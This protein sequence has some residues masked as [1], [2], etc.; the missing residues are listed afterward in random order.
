[1]TSTKWIVA[2]IAYMTF[3]FFFPI[4]VSADS[5]TLATW[6]VRILSDSSRTD[7]ELG[8]IAQIMSRYDFIAVQEIRDTHVMDRL[9]AMLPRY[10]H[11]LN[12]GG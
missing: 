3:T 8:Q 11:V 9:M 10:T 6:N 12:R 2:L 4:A 5:I 7:A 1:M